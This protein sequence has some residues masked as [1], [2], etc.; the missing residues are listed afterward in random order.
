MTQVLIM[1]SNFISTPFRLPVD[2]NLRLDENNTM[3][4]ANRSARTFSNRP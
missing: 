4:E 3:N 2:L 1:L